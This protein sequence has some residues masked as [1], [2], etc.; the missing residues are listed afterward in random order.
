[1]SSVALHEE[2]KIEP[3]GYNLR[4][5]EDGRVKVP[6]RGKKSCNAGFQI[7]DKIIIQ[8]AHSGI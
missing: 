6:V 4:G 8:R 2:I 5:L 1:M 3:S 7:K